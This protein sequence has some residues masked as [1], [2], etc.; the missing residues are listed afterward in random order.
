MGEANVADKMAEKVTEPA[1]GIN[2]QIQERQQ[3]YNQ[4]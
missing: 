3:I 4:G 2:A 1:K